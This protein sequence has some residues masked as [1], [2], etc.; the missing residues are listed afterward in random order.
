MLTNL[1]VLKKM[2]RNNQR[3][4]LLN[5]SDIKDKLTNTATTVTNSLFIRKSFFTYKPNSTTK[6]ISKKYIA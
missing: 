5:K 6:P 1:Y 4:K 3:P 2:A